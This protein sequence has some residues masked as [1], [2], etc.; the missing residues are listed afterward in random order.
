WV[1]DARS[2]R[3]NY[4][5]RQRGGQTLAQIMAIRSVDPAWLDV[6]LV[7]AGPAEQPV[8]PPTLGTLAVDDDG[9][10]SVPVTAVPVDGEA[11][12]YYAISATQPAP[13]SGLWTFL[14]RLSAPG[15]LQTPP[16]P[17]GVTVWVRARGE[18]AGRRPS[19]YTVPISIVVPS[20]PRVSGVRIL[21]ADGVATV[22]WQPNRVA[23]GVRIYW[24]IHPRGVPPTYATADVEAS[25]GV[26][27]VPETMPVGSA[28]TV[29]VEPWTGW[30]GT[31]VSGTAGPRVVTASIYDLGGP[32]R[33]VPFDD[34]KYAVI[35]QDPSG[36]VLDPVVTDASGR[37]VVR[38]FA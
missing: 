4:R 11:A 13:D 22:V 9:V 25:T 31:A 27:T 5:T 12:V 6:T 38:F 34:G 28:I 35:A 23:A 10:V 18:A 29:E 7:D 36:Q 24:D 3:P 19:P 30:T 37:E 26:F 20:T 1:I 8:Q 2:W 32:R 33:E 17:A 14:G 16:L 15:T 21:I